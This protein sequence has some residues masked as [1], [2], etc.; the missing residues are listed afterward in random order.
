MEVEIQVNMKFQQSE[1][2]KSCGY[3]HPDSRLQVYFVLRTN[4]PVTTWTDLSTA[5]QQGNTKRDI[6][7]SLSLCDSSDSDCSSLNFLDT[8]L[9]F[10][11]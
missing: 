1:L 7:T 9:S 10:N 2:H 4:L 3:L 8:N 11:L 5:A 6:Y